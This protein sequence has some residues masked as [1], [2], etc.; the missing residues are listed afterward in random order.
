M[1]T[2]MILKQALF[3]KA[4]EE[5]APVSLPR[6]WNAQDGQDGGNDYWRGHGHYRSSC[7]LPPPASGSTSSS[8]VP[9][10]LRASPSTAWSSVNTAA[11]SPL[12]VLN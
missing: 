9:T 5:F 8:R 6:T 1:R 3:A 10:T 2:E 11:V 4:G 7:P 12:S